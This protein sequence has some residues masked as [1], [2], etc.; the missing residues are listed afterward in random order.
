MGK[1]VRGDGPPPGGG[2]GRGEGKRGWGKGEDQSE[3]A[4]PK[5]AS[6]IC[7]ESKGGL[8]VTHKHTECVH[9]LIS[10]A[11]WATGH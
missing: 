11:S 8:Q 5:N 2:R 6:C 3:F 10:E 7:F 4:K 9:E 1:G